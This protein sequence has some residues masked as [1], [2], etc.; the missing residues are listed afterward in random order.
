MTRRSTATL[1][2][3][4]LLTVLFAIGL[5]GYF[6]FRDGSASGQTRGSALADALPTPGDLTDAAATV[7][8]QPIPKFQFDTSVALAEGVGK[9]LALG[10]NPAPAPSK[11]EIL[12]GIIDAELK[13]QEARRLGITAS[14]SE[15]DAAVAQS[16]KGLEDPANS[17]AR[18]FL[19]AY[20]AKT[21]QAYDEYWRDVRFREVVRKN[22]V[23]AKFNDSLRLPGADPRTAERALSD[24]LATLRSQADIKIL[25]A[26]D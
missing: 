20:L 14:N 13:F 11:S 16:R 9:G 2:G 23:I 6:V 4:A 25:V 15:V 8:G 22:L 7:N 21:G 5:G 3:T 1:V 12:Q 26:L 19:E 10:G 18:E 17:N 24:K